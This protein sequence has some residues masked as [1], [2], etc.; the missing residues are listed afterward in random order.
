MVAVADSCETFPAPSVAVA[1]SVCDPADASVSST[2]HAPPAA[3]VASRFLVSPTTSYTRTVE[4]ASALPLARNGS[5]ALPVSGTVSVGAEGALRS[6]WIEALVA[7][8]EV[9]PAASVVVADRA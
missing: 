6:T 2:L 3:T 4:L 5:F 8:K 1:V 9:F 7:V